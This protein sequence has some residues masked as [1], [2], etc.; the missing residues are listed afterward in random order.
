MSPDWPVGVLA[1]VLTPGP[2][3]LLRVVPNSPKLSLSFKPLFSQEHVS[4]LLVSSLRPF[5]NVHDLSRTHIP[6][7]VPLHLNKSYSIE[8]TLL[9]FETLVAPVLQTTLQKHFF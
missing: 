8:I 2:Q 7:S 9:M 1:S 4:Y 5:W 6:L 3:A